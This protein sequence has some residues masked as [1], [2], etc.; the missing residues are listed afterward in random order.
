MIGISC[1]LYAGYL[2]TTNYYYADYYEIKKNEKE[3]TVYTQTIDPSLPNFMGLVLRLS[4]KD[5]SS[6]QSPMDA[7]QTGTWQ[8]Y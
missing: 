6:N 3:R 1:L 7:Q 2:Q 8:D 4:D 5:I